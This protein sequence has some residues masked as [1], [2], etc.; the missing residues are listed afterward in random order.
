MAWDNRPPRDTEICRSITGAKSKE[1]V[2]LVRLSKH[3]M[4][5]DNSSEE[6]HPVALASVKDGSVS[7]GS[8]CNVGHPVALASVKHG[9]I[10]GGNCT[11]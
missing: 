3:F 10:S 1:F 9:S 6:G 8:S 2:H 4:I 5:N 11:V 7:S